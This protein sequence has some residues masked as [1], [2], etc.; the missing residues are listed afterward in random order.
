MLILCTVCPPLIVSF[1]GVGSL[2]AEGGELGS[3]SC[4]CFPEEDNLPKKDPFRFGSIRVGL[5]AGVAGDALS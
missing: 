1:L 5:N 3:F 2:I 4:L